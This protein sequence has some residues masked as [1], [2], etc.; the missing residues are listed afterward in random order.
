MHYS[1]DVFS[2]VTSAHKICTEKNGGRIL[3]KEP[4]DFLG[5]FFDT[6]TTLRQLSDKLMR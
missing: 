2:F 6:K 4:Q 1:S 5:E 3:F